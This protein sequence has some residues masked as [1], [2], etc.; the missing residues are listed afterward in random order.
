MLPKQPSPKKGKKQLKQRRKR[1][2]IAARAV[3]DRG[4]NLFIRLQESPEGQALWKL[5]TA[6]RKDNPGGRTHGHLDGY[7]EKVFRKLQARARQ[8]AKII[9][10]YM[11][12]NEMIPK[13]GYAKE[14][15]EAAV[16]LVR[17]TAIHP[18][19]KLAAAKVVLDFTM[20]KPAQT[21]NA[22][23]KTAEDFLDEVAKDAGIGT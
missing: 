20:A 18:R 17:M 1:Q 16:E 14:A 11:M 7:T 5:W 2:P 21:I 8:E 12:E 19:D 10:E 9:V 4:K 15:L 13:D 23:V 6:R 22:N 3:K